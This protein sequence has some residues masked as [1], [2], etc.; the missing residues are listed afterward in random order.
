M[1]GSVTPPGHNEAVLLTEIARTSQAVAGSSGRRAKIELLARCL[2]DAGPAEAA[3][4]VAY[5]SGELP[6][7][8]IGVGHAALREAPGP[9]PRPVL[10]VT[11][12]DAVF[13]EI[14]GLSGRGSVAARRELLHGLLGRATR[15]EQDFLVR[16]LSGE[17]RQGALDGVMAEAV[18]VA[19]GVPAAEVRRAAM[20]RGSLPPVA[21]AAL[22]QGVEALRGFGL[23]VGRPIRPMLAAAA[24]SIE[25]ALAKL[26]AP[27]TPVG[28][29]WKLDGIRAQIHVQGSSVGVFTRTLDD[30]TGRL[31]EVVAALRDLPVRSAVFD[32]EVI[33]LRPDGRPHPFQITSAR[34]ASHKDPGIPLSV[35]LFDTLHLDGADLLDRPGGERH[36]ALAEVVPGELIMPRLVTGSAAEATDFF[37][38]AVAHGHEGVV[39][40][41]LDTPYTAGRRGAGWIKVKPRHTL[42]LVILAV[43]WGH[44]RRTGKLSNLHL[45]ARDPST[46]EF[47]MLGKTFKGLTDEMLAWQTERLRE[48]AVSSDA[49]TVRVRPELVVEVA[50]DGVQRSS[51]YPGGMALRFARVLRHRP[52]KSP[53]E[54]DTVET[55]RT[56]AALPEAALPE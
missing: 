35:F 38:G 26:G 48:L 23:E 32:G 44:G 50:F 29:E 1:C 24:P 30:I 12:V 14:G 40:K 51:R 46:G 15:E 41:S 13:S 6:Q 54:A 10:T 49:W 21:T 56:L 9:A 8:Q 7:R 19:A 18:A 16:L 25:E 55:V 17:L 34:T 53:A 52:D 27:A 36:G 31:P 45:G 37:T 33:A 11:E 20:L 22:H 3:V 47:V 4:A 28:V 43:E 2:R 42:D 5:L 39:V